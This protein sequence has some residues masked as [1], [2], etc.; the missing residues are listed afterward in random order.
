MLDL[1]WQITLAT[2]A[3]SEGPFVVLI[4]ELENHLH[5]AAQRTALP[6]LV[7]A[8]PNAK[9]I[10]ATHSPHVFASI[11]D[12]THVVLK[13]AE[14]GFKSEM[15]DMPA[16]LLTPD[17]VLREALGLDVTM[18][19]WVEEKL[20]EITSRHENTLVSEGGFESLRDELEDAGLS[21]L[22]PSATAKILESQ[23]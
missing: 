17:E 3:E 18:P 13:R 10:V 23:P 6:A 15:V 2:R 14:I 9:F 1:A 19:V 8:F 20:E 7:E 11:E 12:A 16:S 21:R 4:D 5:P 22:L